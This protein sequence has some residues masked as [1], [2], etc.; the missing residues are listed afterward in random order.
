M[1]G[2]STKTY[3]HLDVAELGVRSD[4]Q[5]RFDPNLNTSPTRYAGNVREIAFYSP[6]LLTE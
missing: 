3:P 5:G 6:C 2:F 4:S 1:A